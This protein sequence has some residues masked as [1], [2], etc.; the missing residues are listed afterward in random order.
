M[1]VLLHASVFGRNCQ[2][3]TISALLKLIDYIVKFQVID[4]RNMKEAN[5]AAIAAI[6]L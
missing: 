3:K 4:Y 5:A 1:F 2:L 6:G